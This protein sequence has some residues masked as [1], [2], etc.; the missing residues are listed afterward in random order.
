MRHLKESN[1]SYWQHWVG[2]IKMSL[3]LFIHAWF[4]FWYTTYASDKLK[5]RNETKKE[6]SKV[7]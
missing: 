5:D 3:A 2:A 1:M 7:N 6:T 4:P